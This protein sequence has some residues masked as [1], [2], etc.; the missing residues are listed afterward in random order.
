MK[1]TLYDGLE[2]AKCGFKPLGDIH[3]NLASRH[4]LRLIFQSGISKVRFFLSS[5]PPQKAG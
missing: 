2:V 5:T 4:A 1:L 3:T